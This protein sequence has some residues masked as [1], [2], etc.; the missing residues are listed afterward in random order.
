MNRWRLIALFIIYGLFAGCKKEETDLDKYK[1]QAAVD[2]KLIS[3]YIAENHLQDVAK[4]VTDTSGAYYIVKNAGIGTSLFTNS[5]QVTV[6][7]T[8]ILLT[9]GK[10]FQEKRDFPPSFVLRQ[11]ILGWIL[12]I[13]K[14][15][16]GGEVRVILP[17]SFA[18]GPFAQPGLGLPA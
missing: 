8:G 7:D 14:I 18:F 1:A 13:T 6:S 17:S 5:T 12:G 10:T 3:N 9:K 15:N 11:T 4:K 2:D 16:K